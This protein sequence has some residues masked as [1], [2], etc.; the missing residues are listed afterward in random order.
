MLGEESDNQKANSGERGKSTS[1][2]KNRGTKWRKMLGNVKT[3]A[4]QS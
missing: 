4:K 2:K 3:K 1:A